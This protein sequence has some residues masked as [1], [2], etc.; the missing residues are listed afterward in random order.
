[1]LTYA[2]IKCTIKVVIAQV[3]FVIFIKNI[4]L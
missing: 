2:S 4:G 3:Y 1:M